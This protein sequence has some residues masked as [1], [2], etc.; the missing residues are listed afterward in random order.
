MIH[1]ILSKLTI[2]DI[3]K[4]VREIVSL[5]TKLRLARVVKVGGQTIVIIDVVERRGPM[6]CNQ[7]LSIRDRELLYEEILDHGL[8][9][10]VSKLVLVYYKNP[11]RVEL[12]SAR[13][14]ANGDLDNEKTLELFLRVLENWAP[15]YLERLRKILNKYVKTSTSE[16][17]TR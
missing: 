13:I 15:S 11:N 4:D 12:I 1:E 17:C 2:L 6:S 16:Q 9:P 3:G 7:R 14:Y 5:D 10:E 8:G